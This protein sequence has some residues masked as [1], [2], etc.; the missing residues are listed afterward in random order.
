VIV[1][2]A[3]ILLYLFQVLMKKNGFFGTC[4]N[5]SKMVD[6]QWKAYQDVFY[7]HFTW[8][9]LENALKW[10]WMEETRVCVLEFR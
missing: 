10:K 6:E 2:I 3:R 8:G 1:T 7:K 5:A 9:V 4:V